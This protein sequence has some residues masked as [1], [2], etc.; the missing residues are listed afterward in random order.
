MGLL[1]AGVSAASR[2]LGH[3]I[4]L[5]TTGLMMAL[6]LAFIYSKVK[7]R[8]Q[9]PGSTWV[10]WYGP[11]LTVLLASMF[12]MAEPL[13]HVLQDIDVW[14]ECGNNDVFPRVNETWNDGCKW[15]STQYKCEKLCYVQPGDSDFCASN[16]NDEGC[17]GNV[18]LN[19]Y[20]TQDEIEKLICA[21][22]VDADDCVAADDMCHCTDHETFSNLS[23]IG[24]IFTF[25][26]TYFGFFVLTVGVMWNAEIVKK[27][28]KIKSQ[29]RAL[30]DPEYRRKLK[31]EA[32][33]EVVYVR[34]EI[35]K[36]KVLMFSKTTCPFCFK[37]KEALNKELGGEG[38]FETIELDLVDNGPAI[39]D[40]LKIVTGGRTVPRVF[41][42]GQFIGGGDDTVAKQAS[43][44]L[45]E[46]LA[47]AGA[48]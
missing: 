13:R 6:V 40:A 37:A 1:G 34:G 39:Q 44:E 9:L 47:T 28:A 29:Y 4:S 38:G 36:H 48:V 22:G 5:G 46:L 14:P 7:L 43:G 31:D 33:G 21:P 24:W 11:F 35:A 3:W 17:G 12:I 32:K 18:K 45:R 30:R 8:K 41:I 26:F 27:F 16:P 25:T 15:S 19:E 23:T 42:N 2:T 20:Y 10:H